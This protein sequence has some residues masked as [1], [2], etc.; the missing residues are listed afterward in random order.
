MLEDLGLDD[1][2]RNNLDNVGHSSVIIKNAE[3]IST[4]SSARKANFG[5]IGAD[6]DL[7]TKGYE[8]LQPRI[9]DLDSP[10]HNG[11]DGIYRAP[12]GSYAIVEG[13]YTVSAVLNPANPSTGLL[14]QM[15]N[16]WI[17]QNNGQRLLEALGGDQAIIDDILDSGYSRD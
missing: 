7:N 10:G 9:T 17:H 14:R 12:D 8:S 3:N 1:V 13:I 4:T 6:L 15:S 5:E 11:I 2:A 16:D